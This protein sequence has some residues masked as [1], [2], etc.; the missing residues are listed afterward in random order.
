MGDTPILPAHIEETVHAIAELHAQHLRRSTP[1]QRAVARAT[2]F[3]G[4]PRFVGWLTLAI[5]VW[6]GA[7]ALV[8]LAG[9]RALD[10]APFAYL[11]D[12]GEL[13]G[14]YITLLIL[15]T[16]RR[17]D[18]M[19]EA[20]E[21]LTLELA[22]LG[23]QKNAKIIALLEELRRDNPMIYD[24]HDAEAEALSTPADPQAVLD[25]IKDSHEDLMG[26]VEAAEARE[27]AEEA[28]SEGPL[29]LHAV[30]GDSSE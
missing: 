12:A 1:V 13:L 30:E 26:E 18:Q 5:V 21:Q 19:A 22:I 16:Q 25:A 14:L 15:V 4:R 17:D 23:E 28:V 27:A 29:Q 2:D 20:R 7:N 3:I 24:R 11:Q 8:Q 10:P 9:A 6:V